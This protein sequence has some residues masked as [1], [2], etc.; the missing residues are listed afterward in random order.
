MHSAFFERNKTKIFIVGLLALL[1]MIVAIYK[2]LLSP[3]EVKE[4]PIQKYSV[5]IDQLIEKQVE[6]KG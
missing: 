4:T 5:T 2:L 1:L 3:V 6:I